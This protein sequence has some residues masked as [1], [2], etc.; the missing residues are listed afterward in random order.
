MEKY[1]WPFEVL[2]A[3]YLLKILGYF[4]LMV[5]RQKTNKKNTTRSKEDSVLSVDIILPMYNEEKVVADTIRNL[6]NIRYSPLKIIVVD[7]GSTDDSFG[8]VKQLFEGHP[9]IRLVHQ[10]NAGKSAAMNKAIQLSESDII[11][12]IDADTWVRPDAIENIVSHFAD[13]KVAAVAGHLMVGNRV[14][15]L[16]EIQYFE[17]VAVWDNDRD[18]SDTVDGILI[19]PGAFGAFRRSAVNSVGGFRTD[20]IAEDTEL[21]IRL[22]CDHFILRN[23]R[24]AVAYT[25][26]PDKLKMFL[27]QRVRWTIGLMQGLLQH[28]KSMFTHPNRQLAYLILPFTWMVRLFLPFLVPLVDYYFLYTVV[29]REHFLTSA[30]WLAIILT[31]SLTYM[32]LLRKSNERI[33]LLKSIVLQRLYRHLVFLTYW[34]MLVKAFNGTLFRWNKITRKGNISLGNSE[35]GYTDPWTGTSYY[36]LSGE[37]SQCWLYHQSFT[38]GQTHDILGTSALVPQLN[39]PILKETIAWVIKRHEGL[40]TFFKVTEDGVRQ[41]VMPYDETVFSPL[42]FDFRNVSD[43]DTRLAKGTK[44][45]LEQKK[46]LSDLQCYPPF[47]ICIFMLPDNRCYIN[48]MVHHMVADDLSMKLLRSELVTIYQCLHQNKPVNIDPPEMQPREYALWQKSWIDTN[49]NTIRKYWL[50]TLQDAVNTQS[51]ADLYKHYR[52]LSGYSYEDA[53]QMTCESFYAVLDKASTAIYSGRTTPAGYASLLG[54]C[55]NY[56][57]TM[58]AVV[59][60]SLQLLFYILGRPKLLIYAPLSSRFLHGAESLVAYQIGA[61]YLYKSVSP[62]KTVKDLMK[63]CQMEYLNAAQH[64]IFDHDRMGLDNLPVRMYC[65]F[66]LNFANREMIGEESMPIDDIGRHQLMARVQYHILMIDTMEFGDGLKFNW[67][68]NTEMYS[69]DTIEYM[70]EAQGR[71]LQLICQNPGITVSELLE[72]FRHKTRQYEPFVD[73]GR[74]VRRASPI[75]SMS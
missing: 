43:E 56:K 58:Q 63:D 61:L 23:A 2:M 31:E 72:Q 33:S 37:Q 60:S 6:L 51:P 47:R 7:D 34:S 42:E 27:R 70:A 44:I 39:L 17:Y 29:F 57:I 11:V 38:A 19:I 64:L 3:I 18:F 73:Y 48:M 41:C 25:E 14:N 15:L 74:S 9:R 62:L 53:E 71:L 67:K 30:W 40:R 32:Y 24:D 4:T 5:I 68:Y 54:I 22:Q 75:P 45:I 55:S 50:A 13:E 69:P 52:K 66:M 16:T 28:N 12:T 46:A 59:V 26:A 49:Y 65:G 8:I 35:P 20:M 21:T 10:P 36:E 1:I